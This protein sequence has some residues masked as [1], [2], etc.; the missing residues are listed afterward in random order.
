MKT[1]CTAD[2]HFDES[3]QVPA[4]ASI[5]T[6]AETAEREKPA[7]VTISGDL[8]NR[9]VKNTAA[10]GFVTLL[11]LIKRILDVCPIAAVY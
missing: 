7:I 4:L 6:L 8:F 9:A 3:N 1:I 2:L 11:G 5:T 10:S